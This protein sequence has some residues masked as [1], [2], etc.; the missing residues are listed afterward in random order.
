MSG[1]IMT[2]SA[3]SAC[4]T[5]WTRKNETSLRREEM[6]NC[7]QCGEEVCKHGECFCEDSHIGCHECWKERR[8]EIEAEIEAAFYAHPGWKKVF[9]EDSE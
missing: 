9:E 7:E 4:G 3:K 8:M 5:F 2:N 6:E 1:K